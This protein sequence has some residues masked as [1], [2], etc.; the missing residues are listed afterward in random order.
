[1]K[2]TDAD[3]A[4]AALTKGLISREGHDL[5]LAEADRLQA[6]GLEKSVDEILVERGDITSEHARSLREALGWTVTRPRIGG[7]EIIRRVGIG[8]M[9][10]VFEARHVRLNQRIALKV[11]FPRLAKDPRLAERF[12]REARALAKLDHQ[13]LVHAIDAGHDGEHYYLAM[14]LI[15]GENLLQRLARAGPLDPLSSLDVVGSVCEALGVLEEKGLVHRDVKPGN[16]LIGSRGQV[17]LADLGLFKGLDGSGKED[18]VCGTPHYMAPEQIRG[19]AEVDTRTD[20]YSLGATWYHMV[21][22][23]P[24]F[25][26]TRTAEILEAQCTRDPPLPSRLRPG[27]PAAMERVILRWLS[28]NREERPRDARAALREVEDLDRSLRGSR[29]A[30]LWRKTSSR[31]RRSRRALLVTGGCIIIALAVLLSLSMTGRGRSIDPE[32][33]SLV[34]GVS[35]E[36]MASEAED[37]PLEEPTGASRNIVEPAPEVASISPVPPRVPSTAVEDPE[38]TAEMAPRIPREGAGIVDLLGRLASALDETTSAAWSELSA[39]SGHADP[40]L[41]FSRTFRA[42]IVGV[43]PGRSPPAGIVLRYSFDSPRELLDFRAAPGSWEVRKGE[44][45]G[46]AGPEGAPLESVAWFTPP[47][48]I[49][50]ELP[51]E[52]PCILGFG[53][54]RIAPGGAEDARVW[55]DD[56]DA[57]I[58]VLAAPRAAAGRGWVRIDPAGV[59]I[60]AGGRTARVKTRVPSRGRV[61]FR[62]ASGQAFSELGVEGVLE[63]AWSQARAETARE[64]H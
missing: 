2:A 23:R 7:Y 48:R 14:E 45:R 42:G 63:P 26:G 33:D 57:R 11:L 58:W 18:P 49:E 4:R 52:A 27:V 40:L 20:L 8:G 9:G 38:P 5:V 56:P 39:R 36:A 13:H 10:T 37:P 35:P 15:E 19:G 61:T 50:W 24:P 43:E 21:V 60:A 1:M 62:I 29:L 30:A 44:L 17:K 22:G 28:K 32:P 46:L 51:V 3:F 16:I 12:L 55:S 47:V 59:E 41:P 34:S 54:L 53:S 31:V 25:V 64:Q 6:L